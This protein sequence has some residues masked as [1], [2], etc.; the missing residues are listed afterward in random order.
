MK[1]IDII[2]I[3]GKSL[4]ERPTKRKVKS[5]FSVGNPVNVPNYQEIKLY[6]PAIQEQSGYGIAYNVLRV[7][8]KLIS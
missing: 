2:F 4:A 7:S 8:L 1:E 6:K 5:V 3:R